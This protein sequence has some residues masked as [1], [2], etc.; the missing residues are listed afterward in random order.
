VGNTELKNK[1]NP[2]V[3]ALCYLKQFSLVQ[4]SILQAEFSA[5]YQISAGIKPK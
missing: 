5:Y 1:N 3:H 4:V 2:L